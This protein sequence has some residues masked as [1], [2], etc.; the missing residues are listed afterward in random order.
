MSDEIQI[1]VQSLASRSTDISRVVQKMMF[2]LPFVDRSC[3]V[4]TAI[5]PDIHRELTGKCNT[6][7]KWIRRPLPMLEVVQVPDYARGLGIQA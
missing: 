1:E 7:A 2:P 3:H 5:G 6:T 4:M